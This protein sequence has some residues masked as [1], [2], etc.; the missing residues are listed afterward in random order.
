LYFI[1]NSNV[2]RNFGLLLQLKK[3]GDEKRKKKKRK[4]SSDGGGFTGGEVGNEEEEEEEG[5]GAGKA[6]KKKVSGPE[7]TTPT[8]PKI[9]RISVGEKNS[10]SKTKHVPGKTPSAPKIKQILVKEKSPPAASTPTGKLKHKKVHK[11]H[12]SSV[13]ESPSSS[14]RTAGGTRGRAV[15]LS[16]T[17]SVFC[18]I[19]F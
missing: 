14:V 9:K 7:K 18:Y 16:E 15:S 4:K 8:A 13:D 10:S 19:F 6:K 2:T 5:G 1:V 12:R 3:K 11:K 17:V